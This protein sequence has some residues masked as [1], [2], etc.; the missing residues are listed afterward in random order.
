MIVRC[1]YSAEIYGSNRRPTLLSVKIESTQCVRQISRQ[2]ECIERS[3]NFVMYIFMIYRLNDLPFIITNEII[4]FFFFSSLSELF[5][6]NLN[7]HL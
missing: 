4:D 1:I 6:S 2:I 7:K 5:Y 3:S